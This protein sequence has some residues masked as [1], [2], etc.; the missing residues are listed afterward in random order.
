MESY[1]TIPIL[2]LNNKI[3]NIYHINN[4]LNILNEYF[5]NKLY[6]N[7]SFN[8]DNDIDYSEI[9]DLE[10]YSSYKTPKNKNYIKKAI[11]YMKIPDKNNI[12]LSGNLDYGNSGLQRNLIKC[13][14]CYD[15]ILDKNKYLKL[16]CSHTFCMECYNTWNEKCYSN[17]ICTSCPMCREIVG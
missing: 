12:I 13:P 5:C 8:F 3:N 14:I 7:F 11:F 9:D 15:L 6:E 2:N 4:K 10:I 17:N 16:T 1:I